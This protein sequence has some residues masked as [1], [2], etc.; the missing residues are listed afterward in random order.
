MPTARTTTRRCT[1]I[2]P[3]LGAR[4]ADH[5]SPRRRALITTPF[6]VRI[7]APGAPT[8]KNTATSTDQWRTPRAISS[9]TTA[10]ATQAEILTRRHRTPAS[11]VR[12]LTTGAMHI[13][14]NRATLTGTATAAKYGVPTVT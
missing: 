3:A 7:A 10:S 9:T 2:P 12:Q 13:K 8:D 1:I 6:K 11:T 4:H 14:N 5:R